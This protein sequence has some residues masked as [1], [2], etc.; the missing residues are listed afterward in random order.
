MVCVAV[1]APVALKLKLVLPI[2]EAT[3]ERR[4]Q[5]ADVVMSPGAN[6]SMHVEDA[7]TANKE[8]GPSTSASSPT[9]RL[10]WSLSCH[11]NAHHRG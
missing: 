2:V 1:F 7:S 4:N 8:A 10:Q 9:V 11:V 3:D 6:V 5:A